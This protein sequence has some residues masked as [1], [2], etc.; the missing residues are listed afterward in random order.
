MKECP[1]WLLG[2]VH[3]LKLAA[4]EAR[5]RA[6]EASTT[7]L[8]LRT[9]L[10]DARAHLDRATVPSG[11][12]RQEVGA[13]V[14]KRRKE[15]TEKISALEPQVEASKEIAERA[16]E[17]EIAVSAVYERCSGWIESGMHGD[18]DAFEAV[19]IAL[20]DDPAARVKEVEVE[21]V[22]LA[23]EQERIN[24]A[25]VARVDLETQVRTYLSDLR[26]DCEPKITFE[27]GKVDIAL[28]RTGKRT[29]LVG[30][31]GRRVTPEALL[32]LALW[33]DPDKVEQR[34]YEIVDR[35]P[36]AAGALPGDVKTRRLH[37][38]DGKRTAALFELGALIR[39]A[40]ETG[41]PV[42]INKGVQAE[43]VLGVRVAQRT[44]AAA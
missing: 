43:H 41:T 2:R 39:N 38:I 9:E 21:I 35:I 33:L 27:N 5:E 3:R 16:T 11:E 18:D 30:F 10:D 32:A 42:A 37:E 34:V 19:D 20:P 31:P 28:A 26:K 36:H 17:Y 24:A 14:E 22:A 7:L 15:L 8:R 29:D 13:R 44:A 6:E 25:P 40:I 23:E 1:E 12:M 4:K